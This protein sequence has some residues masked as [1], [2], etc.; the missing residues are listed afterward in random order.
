[1]LIKNSRISDYE[2]K[3]IIWHFVVD[4]SA[5]QCA[6]LL[7]INRNTINRYY[8]IFREKIYD[9]QME[10]MRIKLAW[11]LEFDESYFWWR[12]VK[13]YHWN[14]RWRW[15]LKQPVFWI[16]E[17]DGKVYTEIIPDCKKKTLQKIIRWK[18]GKE[19]I[20]YT[21]WRRWYD[22][23]VD[24]WYDKHY[25]VNHSK[26]EFSKWKW[27]H[28]NGIEA[29]RSFCKRRLAKFNWVKINFSL[30]LKE[31]DWRYKKTDLEL[32][33]ELSNI[34]VPKKKSHKGR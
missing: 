3:K 30:H 27:V 33:K 2:I 18:V 26:N 17:R 12:R 23:L 25:R 10:E 28:I 14:K 16:F 11:K 19:A 32:V 5:T 9:Y 4:I 15:T 21:D 8:N 13:W 24:V 20:I 6:K 1:M 31:C 7:W 22:W 29:Y 34:L